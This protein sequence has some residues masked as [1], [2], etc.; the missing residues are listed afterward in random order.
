V[1]PLPSIVF[2]GTPD[3]AVPS[4]LALHDSGFPVKLV[5]TQPDRAKGRGRRLAPPPVKSE[6]LALNLTVEQPDNIRR[7]DVVARLDALAPDFLVVVAFGQI[8]P[9][10][11]LSIPKRGAVNVHASLLPKYRGPAPI[12]WAL[13]RGEDETGITT[14]LMDHGVD[15]GDILLQVTTP[16]GA[17]DTAESLHHRL[18]HMGARL[19]VETLEKLWQ[20]SLYPTMQQHSQATY[21]PMLKK[22]DGLI[23]WQKSARQL[24]AFVRAMTP[25]P[26]AFCFWG[27]RRLRIWKTEPIQKACDVAPGTVVPG[28]AD[29]LR[30]AS[31]DGL[32]SVVEIQ[33]DS[34]KRMPIRD[35]LR[36]NPIPAGT[37]LST[38]EAH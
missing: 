8:L 9:V 21:A 22:Q 6:A 1:K 11:I 19:L 17:C 10:S 25:W 34:G 24:D 32:L 20:G 13:I 38:T 36:G 26:G 4:L 27:Q 35:Y 5:V 15:T 33:G 28:F 16:I 12:Q 31:S 18:A 30:V 23:D 7:P 2:M 29:E 14:M 3:F 37:V